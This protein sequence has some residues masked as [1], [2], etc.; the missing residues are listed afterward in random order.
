MACSL[1]PYLDKQ[2]ASLVIGAREPGGLMLTKTLL[3]LL[4]I[5]IVSCGV[6]K[7]AKKVVEDSDYERETT[8]P[9]SGSGSGKNF[10]GV[11][12]EPVVSDPTPDPVLDTSTDP[13]LAYG[14]CAAPCSGAKRVFFNSRYGK[15][16]QVVLC[17]PEVY[18]LF[19]GESQNGPFYKIGDTGGHGQDHCELV[20]NAFT[21]PNN[22][23]INSG[24]CPTCQVT[25]AGSVQN[26]PEL[27]GTNVYHRSDIGEPFEFEQAL[28]WGIH[29]SCTYSCGVSF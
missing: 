6:T 3:I 16:I 5:L 10:D 26:I 25:G 2:I 9:G 1:Q 24:N 17:T 23:D 14:S 4:S 22:D 21:M 28:Q 15:W 7:P 19:M 11:P 8:D 20:N 18:D 27:W 29:T 12:T 13:T